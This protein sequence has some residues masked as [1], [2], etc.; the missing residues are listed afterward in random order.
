MLKP[1]EAGSR[2][3]LGLPQVH[4]GP[5]SV[6]DHGHAS[7]VH[8]VEWLRDHARAESFHFG[9]GEI[10]IGHGDVGVPVGRVLGTPRAGPRVDRRHIL[11]T[12]AAHRVCG[13]ARRQVLHCP[14]E[15]AGVEGLRCPDLRC[16][17]VDPT[18][19]SV[20]IQAHFSHLDRQPGRRGLARS[21][22]RHWDPIGRRRR[23]AVRH[24][25]GERRRSAH[26]VFARHRRAIRRHRDWSDARRSRRTLRGGGRRDAYADCRGAR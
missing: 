25:L 16:L 19:G 14:P 5:G 9:R 8:D 21:R 23:P 20:G 2:K 17:E 11:P 6:L 1:Y 4:H 22:P 13:L 3:R 12:E 26:A 24:Q 7:G 10:E 18:K 15:Q